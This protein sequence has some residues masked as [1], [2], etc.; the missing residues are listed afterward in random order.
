MWT[1]LN[2]GGIWIIDCTYIYRRRREHW[3][4]IDWFDLVWLG[5]AGGCC[6]YIYMHI[7][8]FLSFVVFIYNTAIHNRYILYIADRLCTN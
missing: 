5:W 4:G 2:W 6:V 8:A 3:I 1:G 7:L